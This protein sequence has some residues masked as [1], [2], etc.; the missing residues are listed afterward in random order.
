MNTEMTME[1]R[2]ERELEQAAAEVMQALGLWR[3]PADPF[4]V[5]RQEGIE[6]A[7]GNYGSRFDARIEYLRDVDTFVLYYRQ[8]EPGRTDGRVRFSIAHE[9]GH[10]YLHRDYLLAGQR[11]NSQSDF[12]SRNPMEQEADE[13]A[14]GLLMPRKLFVDRVRLF[15]GRVCV[16]KDLCHLAENVFSTSVTSTVRRYCQCGI[17][18]ASMVV[19]MNGRVKWAL[20]SED[21][22]RLGFGYIEGGKAIPRTSETAKLWSQ[23]RDGSPEQQEP[24]EGSVTASVWFD[25]GYGRRLWEE[26]MVL[27][28]TGY[29]LTYL[30]MENPPD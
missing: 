9:L 11:H 29:V 25:R 1:K 6:L 18:P 10:Y 27:G 3:V 21:M 5:V 7:P 26:A 22:R 8:A 15:R 30:T 19:S 16:L 12:R 2:P 14:A 28:G 20:A 24:V 17:E 4:A 23:W 13:F